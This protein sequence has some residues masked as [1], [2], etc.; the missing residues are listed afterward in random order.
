MHE[1]TLWN[2]LTRES[3]DVAWHAAQE[4]ITSC[5]KKSDMFCYQVFRKTNKTP[6]CDDLFKCLIYIELHLQARRG[7]YAPIQPPSTTALQLQQQQLATTGSPP[8]ADE[9][10]TAPKP[11]YNARV[12]STSGFQ[13]TKQ[14]PACCT[15]QQW[16][17]TLAATK[18]KVGVLQHMHT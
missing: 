8:P 9:A 2:L 16:Q 18:A 6:S 14:Q 13:Q 7:H 10:R 15:T 12:G 3:K 4:L 17:D 1:Q 11:L 5:S